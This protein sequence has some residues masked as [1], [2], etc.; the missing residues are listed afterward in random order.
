MRAK[1]L[2]Y[3]QQRPNS[4]FRLPHAAMEWKIEEFAFID[5]DSIRAEGHLR[6]TSLYEQ[7]RKTLLAKLPE[8]YK[9]R[10]RTVGFYHDKPVMIVSPYD[11]PYGE[12]R[13][14]WMEAFFKV[15]VRHMHIGARRR[16]AL[17]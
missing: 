15:S 16:S 3:H 5:S 7:E 1:L 12:T 9:S 2:S 8:A 13:R 10:F 17:P 6:L 4:L 14:L 11:V